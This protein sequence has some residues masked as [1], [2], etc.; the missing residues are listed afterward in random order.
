MASP[1]FYATR[2][3]EVARTKERLKTIEEEIQ[4]AYARWMEL[5]TLM[6]DS[7]S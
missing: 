3:D 6:D 4:K 1:A 2:G 5:E 7:A